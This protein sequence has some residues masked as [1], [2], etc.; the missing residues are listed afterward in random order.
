MP[1]TVV[2]PRAGSVKSGGRPCGARERDGGR[3]AG[4]ADV[5]ALIVVLIEAQVPAEAEHVGAAD[6]GHVL[7]QLIGVDRAIGVGI[8]SV[9]HVGVVEGEARRVGEE[10]VGFALREE[11]LPAREAEREL[12]DQ[13]RGE[14]ASETDGDIGSG[15]EDFA[16]RRI[17]GDHN[18]AAVERV[19]VERVLLAAEVAE[20]GGVF[21]V[22][23]V[24]DAA[25]VLRTAH[26][27]RRI[28]LVNA[29]VEAVAR[30]EGVGR[31]VAAKHGLD[32]GI[33]TDP[34]GIVGETL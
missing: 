9:V 30:A 4:A 22:D 24:I 11:E 27:E 21:G 10:R 1:A 16:A 15:T 14:R 28:P 23:G 29:G 7:D 26:P 18:R 13:P 34:D 2:V 19:A 6:E 12:I 8:R 33:E 20:E 32:G 17:T 25:E 3:K 31:G 5:A